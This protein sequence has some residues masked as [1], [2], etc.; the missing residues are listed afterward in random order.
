MVHE[1][2]HKTLHSSDACSATGLHT[3]LTDP[4]LFRRLRLSWWMR[5]ATDHADV[6][7]AEHSD[8]PVRRVQA[9]GS[10][11]ILTLLRDRLFFEPMA[12]STG[13]RLPFATRMYV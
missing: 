7:G 13:Q 3:V 12:L 6:G 10:G 2:G 11:D 8:C 4:A 1:A 5:E 9:F